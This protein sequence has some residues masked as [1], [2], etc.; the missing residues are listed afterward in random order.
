MPLD[1]EIYEH[2]RTFRPINIE[3]GQR[4]EVPTNENRRAVLAIAN[5]MPAAWTAIMIA[6]ELQHEGCTVPIEQV[7]GALAGL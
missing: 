3:A 2:R 4:T 5:R 1:D 7:R 6:E